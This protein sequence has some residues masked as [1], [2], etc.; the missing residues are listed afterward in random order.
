MMSQSAI[1]WRCES[2]RAALGP[3]AAIRGAVG[4]RVIEVEQEQRH[5]PKPQEAAVID[6][7]SR[8]AGCE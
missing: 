1:G 3:A 4:A 8:K 5:G 6:V 2:G 7:T